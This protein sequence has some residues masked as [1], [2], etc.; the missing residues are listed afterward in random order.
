M[1]PTSRGMLRASHSLR[2]AAAA[3]PSQCSAC[4]SA[5]RQFSNSASKQRA[6]K[7]PSLHAGPSS[8]SHAASF[9]T[10][11]ISSAATSPASSSSP[12]PSPS[13]PSTADKETHFGFQSIPESLKE[14]MVG[15]VFSSVA[16][17]Y[18]EQ[19]IIIFY[20]VVIDVMYVDASMRRFSRNR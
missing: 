6:T 20:T 3:A 7:T 12:S 10:S 4:C 18:G 15:G 2:S 5:A 14:S 17:K 16:S 1:L 9:S 8:T 13:S 19:E 11:T